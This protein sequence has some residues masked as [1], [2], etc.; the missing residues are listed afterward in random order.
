MVRTDKGKEFLNKTF[1]DMLKREGIEFSVCRNPK[2]KCT[3]IERTHRSLRDKLFKYFT[4]KNTYSYIDVLQDFVTGYNHTV[5]NT[6]GIAPAHVSNKDVL[7]I[8]QRLNEKASRVLCRAPLLTY[9][10]FIILECIHLNPNRY[11]L[12]HFID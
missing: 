7:T 6:T 11:H 8:W 10:T 1:Q 4:Y 5:H 12:C 9:L 3:V 2:V